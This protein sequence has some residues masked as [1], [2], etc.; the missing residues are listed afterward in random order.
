MNMLLLAASILTVSM[1][2]AE[3]L[4]W[5]PTSP[6][7]AA[8]QK[9]TPPDSDAPLH[10]PDVQPTPGGERDRMR[11]PASGPMGG[12]G[13]Q[14]LLAK[15]CGSCHG[16]EKQKAG[17]RVVPISM[18][19]DGDMRDWVVTPGQPD[20]SELLSRVSLPSG[21]EDIMPPKEPPLSEAEVTRIRA[22]IKGNDTK[23]K[24]IQSAGSIAGGERGPDPRAWA[25]VYLSLDLT[26]SQRKQGMKA[27][28]DLQSQMKK[29]REKMSG[30][31]QDTPAP[32][33]REAGTQRRDNRQQ[34]QAV[35]QKISEV[36]TALWAAL[37]PAQ[38]AA[39]R[40]VLDDPDAIKKAQRAQR[41]RVGGERRPG[42]RRP[43]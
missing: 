33:S 8:K 6:A 2:M 35:Q 17:V 12:D 5:D 21:H 34:R 1:G 32:G 22:W 7:D 10:G 19:F 29:V 15:R 30:R 4:D 18:L 24:L 3:P 39:M 28:E 14:S 40:A 11:G 25:A 41:N 36:Q 42:R 26:D 27:M 9:G 37:T 20:Q 31:G 23:E 38:Q 43:Q 13:V 16:A